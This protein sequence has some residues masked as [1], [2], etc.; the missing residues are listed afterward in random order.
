MRE[1][2]CEDRIAWWGK[3]KSQIKIKGGAIFIPIN[4][5]FQRLSET[6]SNI[7]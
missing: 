1:F 5:L 4:K 3:T 6:P 7:N 2:E